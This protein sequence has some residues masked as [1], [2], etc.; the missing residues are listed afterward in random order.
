MGE[1]AP[2]SSDNPA[3]KEPGRLDRLR[4]RHGWLDHVIRAATLYVERNADVLAGSITYFGFLALFPSL[5]LAA[6]VFGFVLA[7][8]PELLDDVI[9]QIVDYIPGS[10]GDQLVEAL[11]AAIESRNAVGIVGFLGLI[12]AGLAWISKLRLA[13]QTL[14][15]GNPE[16]GSFLRDNARDL[17]TLVG[18]GGG[19]AASL[20]V[21]AVGTAAASF[22]VDLVGLSEFPGVNL[23][24]GALAI[25]LAV[26]GSTLVF[27]WLFG[28]LSGHDITYRAVLPGAILAAVGFEVLKLIGGVYLSLVSNNV[29]AGVFGSVVGILLFIYLACR[30]LLFCVAWTATLPRFAA[31]GLAPAG[32]VGVPYAARGGSAGDQPDAVAVLAGAVSAAGRTS[33]RSTTAPVASSAVVAAGLVATGAV[34]AILT[35]PLVRHWWKR[36]I[37]TPEPRPPRPSL[38]RVAGRR[39]S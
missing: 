22:F 30:F 1:P 24:I 18:F 25:A 11:N 12:Y 6:S 34:V 29:S 37:P 21:T 16:A 38:R 17:L 13:I 27:A 14:W 20:A 36:V 5:L 39:T 2:S 31:L 23:I 4:E 28:S 7:G 8:R 19:L 32:E 35:R 26:A 3:A 33:D 15:Q 10:A 9:A